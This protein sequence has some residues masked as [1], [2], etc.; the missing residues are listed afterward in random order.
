LT[1]KQILV[2]GGVIIE[3]DDYVIVFLFI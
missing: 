3:V 1:K 2:L